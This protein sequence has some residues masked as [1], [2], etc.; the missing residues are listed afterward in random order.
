MHLLLNACGRVD[1]LLEELAC[2]RA[3]GSE[4]RQLACGR[5]A[6][7]LQQLACARVG[8]GEDADNARVQLEPTCRRVGGKRAGEEVGEGA[9]VR[10]PS[11]QT[12][13]LLTDTQTERQRIHE[14]AHLPPYLNSHGAKRPAIE[15][16]L[17]MRTMLRSMLAPSLV[18]TK[19]V[20]GG[21]CRQL[22]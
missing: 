9:R 20:G 13:T 19:C 2:G 5:A 11:I 16:R 7:V 1:A 15:W 17:L 3:G 4:C 18:G 6:E 22:A 8:G 14:C 12:Y 21:E 10:K